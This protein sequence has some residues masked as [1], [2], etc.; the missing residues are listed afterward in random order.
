MIPAI[1]QKKRGV[2]D[3]ANTNLAF[4]GNSLV[5]GVGST[6]PAAYLP[7]QTMALEPLSSAHSS[8]QTKGIGGQTWRQMNGLDGGSSADIDSAWVEGKTNILIAWETTNA[9]YNTARTVAQ[10]A[11]DLADYFLARKA[12]HPWLTVMICT[13]PRGG[14]SRN[15]QLLQVDALVRANPAAYGVDR[16]VETRF[17]GSPFAM[18]DYNVATYDALSAGLWDPSEYPNHIHLRDQGYALVSGWVRDTV[19][20]FNS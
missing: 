11:Q 2:I 19:L 15:L 1:F 16:L 13:I 12:L 7:A 6:G 5:A 18:P 14:D 9:I 4:D 8:W 10:T 3:W 17:A 20:T